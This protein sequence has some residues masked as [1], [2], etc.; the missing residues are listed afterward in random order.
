VLITLFFSYYIEV[1]NSKNV[2]RGEAM[3]AFSIKK[4]AQKWTAF[5]QSKIIFIV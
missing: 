5:K 1:V 4:A 2:F 3:S